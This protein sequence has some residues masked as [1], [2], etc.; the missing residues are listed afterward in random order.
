MLIFYGCATSTAPGPNIYWPAPPEEPRIAYLNAYRGEIDLKKPS[1]WDALF[2]V[3][4]R[5]QMVKPYG[6]T[7]FGEKIY[8]TNTGNA[9]VLILDL[10]EKKVDYLGSGFGLPLGIAAAPDGMIFV[11][12]AKLKRVFGYG[13]DGNLK[14][15]FGDKMLLGPS[16]LAVDGE[17]G[18]IY[19]VDSAGHQFCVFSTK[20][21]LLFKVGN[22]GSGD[23]EFNYP[24]NIAVDRRNHNIY[25]VDT[26]NFRIQVFD[27]DGKFLTRFGSVGD[28][29]GTFTRPKG[30]GIDS[31]GH[32][33]VSDAAFA[34]FQI[35]DE[36]G[37]LLLFIGGHGTGPG[38]FVLP[39]GLYIDEYDRIY[40][41]DQLDPR[42]Q[43]F[44]Y[45]SGKWK[46]EHP[47]E[48]KKYLLPQ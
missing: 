37:E 43:V 14:T 19:V 11:A 23:A 33:F 39:A 7:S 24:S 48:Y 10:K 4:T 31:E 30:I 25:V 1:I 34:N 45:L 26:Q 38:T 3:E 20:G 16:G 28:I 29:A 40:M 46:M 35:F 47:E 6:V 41:V 5:P 36:K 9:T 17:L 15:A 8:V 27:K 13:A 21:Q 2:G 32:V 18:R 22:R 44:Q 42:V 12:D